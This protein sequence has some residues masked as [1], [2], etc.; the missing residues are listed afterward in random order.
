MGTANDPNAMH[1]TTTLT[2]PANAAGILQKRWTINWD[3]VLPSTT[4]CFVHRIFDMATTLHV[5][6][7]IFARDEAIAVIFLS[8]NPFEFVAKHA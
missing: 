1:A 4:R 6:A 5:L 2:H 8:P 7:D 3:Q